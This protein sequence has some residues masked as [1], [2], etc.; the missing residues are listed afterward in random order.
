[1]YI[2][3]IILNNILYTGQS[4]LRTGRLVLLF[5]IKIIYKFGVEF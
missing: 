2:S 4:I 5:F 1:M 3:E